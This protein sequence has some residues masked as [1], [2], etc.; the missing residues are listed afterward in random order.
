MKSLQHKFGRRLTAAIRPKNLGIIVLLMSILFLP[1]QAPAQDI[2]V[3]TLED[4]LDLGEKY[5]EQ[6]LIVEQEQGKADAEVTSARA[7]ALPHISFFGNYTRS[8]EIPEQFVTIGDQTER[9]K[10][11]FEHG[12]TWGFSA[13]QSLFKGGRMF[14]AVTA[15]RLYSRYIEQLR[16]QARLDLQRDIAFAFYDAYL[17]DRSVA[18]AQQALQL[19]IETR[20]VVQQ[21]FDQGQSSE[22]DLLR[23]NVQVANMQPE[24]TRAENARELS[25]TN[26]RVLLGIEA[27]RRVEL[28]LTYPDSSSWESE[29]LTSLIKR[30]RD[31]RPEPL[32]AELEVKL[33][34]KAVTVA[35]A[36]HYPNLDLTGDY[37]VSAYKEKLG[38]D[39]WQRTPSWQAGLSLTI[40]I[41]E[42]WRISSAVTQAKIN[43]SQ[44][45]LRERSVNKLVGL[46]VEK[47]YNDF[48]EARQRL[49][50]QSRTVAQAEEGYEIAQLRYREGI[51]TQLEVTDALLALTT[52]RLNENLALR[53]YLTARVQLRRAVGE[54]VLDRLGGN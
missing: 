8:F 25:L 14:A 13:R 10:F 49:T 21:R 15:A 38:F 2:I 16:R 24:V 7:D 12:V 23:A 22:Y 42:G 53:D 52:A 6:Y 39:H 40:P 20:D 54:P 34:Q 47:A 31:R 45:R 28:Q 37:V 1:G 50:S 33:R 36:D 17:A 29:S 9:F 26:V 35:R 43:L 30:A 51:G 11:G 18:V 3:L 41:F 4:A 46:D 5:N 44:A 48:S 19:T 27:G 32:Q